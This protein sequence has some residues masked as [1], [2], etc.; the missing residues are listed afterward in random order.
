MTTL[1]LD[2]TDMWRKYEVGKAKLA[3]VVSQCGGELTDVSR[4]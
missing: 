4:G 2:I 1:I 3:V